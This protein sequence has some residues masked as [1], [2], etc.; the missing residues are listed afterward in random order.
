MGYKPLAQVWMC[1]D[2]IR[3]MLWGGNDMAPIKDIKKRINY[4]PMCGRKLKEE[5]S[6]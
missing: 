4:C 2:V 6:K 1:D 3:L 5:I